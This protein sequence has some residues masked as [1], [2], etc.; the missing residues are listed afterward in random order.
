MKRIKPKDRFP[1][2]LALTVFGL[3]GILKILRIGAPDIIDFIF[4]LTNAVF[5]G[6]IIW[7][8]IY[9][10]RSLL[11]KK[12]RAMITALSLLMMFYIFVRTCKYRYF[13]EIEIA[14]RY[15]WYL[16][17][18]PQLFAPLIAFAVAD[19]VGKT[20]ESRLSKAYIVLFIAAGVLLFGIMTNDFHQLAF[21]FNPDFENWNSDYGYGPLFYA[22]AVWIYFWIFA[23][24]GL[25]SYKCKAV[26]KKAQLVPVFWLALGTAYIILLSVKSSNMP[27]N[28]PETHCFIFI[29]VIE[30]CIRIGLLPS[31]TG[32]REYIS[33]SSAAVQIADSGGR[34]VYSSKNAV[35]LTEEQMKL[36]VKEPVFID[37]NTVLHSKAVSGG[38]IF[39]T[40][41]I[42][43]VN[44]IIDELIEI[45]ERLN[46]KSRLLKA[47]ADL[48]EQQAR[49]E[50]QNR[51]YDSISVLVKP[52]LE[53]IAELIGNE[54][55][56]NRNMPL[57]CVLICYIKRRANLTLIADG[58]EFLDV[59]ELFLSIKESAEYL[60]L[61]GAPCSVFCD[62]EFMMSAETV[63]LAFD[64]WQAVIEAFLP[65]LEA[66]MAKLSEEN[67]AFVMRITADSEL[68]FALSEKLRDRI[69]NA[70]GEL[71]SVSED[72]TRF[73]TLVLPKGGDGK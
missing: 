53:R 8:M 38:N 60:K 11:S 31:N 27:F 51:L 2:A 66:V 64:L 7:W 4:V 68:E 3:M 56:L 69:E 30:S 33:N 29:A 25:L 23:A 6:I 54:D 55:S 65:G 5:I 42:S 9:T 15:L 12:M 18:L 22:V 58:A 44:K 28:V 48:K 40:D 39:W 49:I 37:K 24:V 47:E 13:D 16:Y 59:R 52:Q 50:E 34:V 73:I 63:L 41:D 36:A 19:R 57:I 26:N 14:C 35:P 17:Y 45:G 43:A 21:R 72:G 1:A 61:Y 71:R 62:G 32:Y 20:E 67:G 70:K 46:E 10:Q